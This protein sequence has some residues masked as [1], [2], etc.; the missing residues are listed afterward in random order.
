MV[1][2]S[3]GWP[4]TREKLREAVKMRGADSVAADIPVH[5]ATVF[6]MLNGDHTP[7]PA[8]Q[9][10]VEQV[11]DQINLDSIDDRDD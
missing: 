2:H 7:S 3:D 9:E 11:L 5:R 4:E 1:R 8:V 10:R 6:R